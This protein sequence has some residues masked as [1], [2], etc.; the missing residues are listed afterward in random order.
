MIQGFSFA[1]NLKGNVVKLNKI[2][3]FGSV[4]SK[5]S[6]HWEGSFLA[7]GKAN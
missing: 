5:T 6:F 1:V 4:G 3:A 7:L 2:I